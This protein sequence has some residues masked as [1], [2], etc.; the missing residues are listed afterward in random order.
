MRRVTKSVLASKPAKRSGRP[1]PVTMG[2]S[3]DVVVH[4]GRHVRLVHSVVLP[5]PVAAHEVGVFV[6]PDA[7]PDD[8][9]AGLWTYLS[10]VRGVKGDT[11][12]ATSALKSLA[13]RRLVRLRQRTSQGGLTSA[14]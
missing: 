10:Q 9:A 11:A 13:E 8:L 14:A 4:A 3:T 1:R 5:V 7:T 6:R 12:V 2:K